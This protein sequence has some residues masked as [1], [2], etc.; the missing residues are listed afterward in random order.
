VRSAI[1]AAQCCANIEALFLHYGLPIPPV[2]KQKTDRTIFRYRLGIISRMNQLVPK[3]FA[4]YMPWTHGRTAV[5]GWREEVARFSLQLVVH[6][7]GR[8][9]ADVDLYNP[10]YGAG[11]AFCHLWECL[12]PGRTDPFKVLD[13]LRSRGID[14]ADVRNNKG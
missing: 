1:K 4:V 6:N 3:H 14:V 13:G 12:W 7:D 11:P 5:K 2:I 10:G 9:E 8:F